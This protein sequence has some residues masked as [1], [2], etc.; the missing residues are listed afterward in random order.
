MFR[1]KKVEGHEQKIFSG[2]LRRI[3]ASHFR[4][5]PGAPYHFEIRSGTTGHDVKLQSVD[6][7]R[8]RFRGHD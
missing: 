8:F 5:G 7:T 6:T 2:A 1:A 4:C 3:S